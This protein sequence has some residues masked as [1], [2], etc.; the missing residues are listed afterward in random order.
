MNMP[1]L[2]G[3]VCAPYTF[4]GSSVG[5]GLLAALAIKLF[6]P[7]C[8]VGILPAWA[9]RGRTDMSI[10]TQLI[11]RNK[12]TPDP[13]VEGTASVGSAER[14]RALHTRL[15]KYAV[16]GAALGRDALVTAV[17]PRFR[18][19]HHACTL[20]AVV[21]FATLATT[22]M[23]A[24]A[25]RVQ[26]DRVCSMLPL[27]LL[28]SDSGVTEGQ[29]CYSSSLT[30]RLPQHDGSANGGSLISVLDLQTC[31]FLLSQACAMADLRLMGTC[32]SE[33]EAASRALDI[34]LLTSAAA[35]QVGLLH[36]QHE[37]CYMG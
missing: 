20:A 24:F 8:C 33:A 10:A 36:Y 29:V 28:G 3:H 2:H 17:N 7:V 5:I 27:T 18:T 15:M 30:N 1:I 16:N 12:I 6:P 34:A 32:A 37:P 13:Y 4:A 35:M 26:C 14:P 22:L 9:K 21:L 11:P 25:L 23:L 31:T 19:F